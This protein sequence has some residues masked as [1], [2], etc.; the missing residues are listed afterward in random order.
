MNNFIVSGN[1]FLKSITFD[2]ENK[3]FN[4]EWTHQL[5]E[6]EKFKTKSAIELINKYQIDGFI[7]NPY[8]EEPIRNK[9]K[10][11]QRSE[12]DIFADYE[13]HK[14]LEWIPERVVMEKKTDVD[15]LITKGVN[16]KTYYDSYEDAVEACIIKNLEILNEIQEKIDKMNKLLPIFAVKK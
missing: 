10:I 13:K 12:Y 3:K 4:I 5:R 6:A 8:K 9:W 11:V 1:G 7:W 15:Y 16:N 2:K 14:V